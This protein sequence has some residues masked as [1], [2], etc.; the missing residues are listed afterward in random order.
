MVYFQDQI[1]NFVRENKHLGARLVSAPTE[2]PCIHLEAVVCDKLDDNFVIP[3]GL[4]I[5]KQNRSYWLKSYYTG[6]F[7][8]IIDRE[9]EREFFR[10]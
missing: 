8:K 4:Q 6:E 3:D 10:K 1:S 5:E 7:I 9:N 2:N